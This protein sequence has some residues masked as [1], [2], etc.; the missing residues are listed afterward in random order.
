MVNK[1]D[2][3]EEKEDIIETINEEFTA[4]DISPE[5][6]EVRLEDKLKQLRQKL[7]KSEEEAKALR[8][9]LA[10]DKADYLN[11]RKRLEDEREQEKE[12]TIVRHAEKLLPLYDSFYLAML[13]KIAWEKADEMWRKGVEGIFN[14]LVGI[15]SGYNITAFD[16]N[17]ETFDPAKHEALTNISVDDNKKHN[18]IL[19]TIQVG[20]LRKDGDTERV[21]RPARV[22]VG[23][24]AGK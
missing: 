19:T 22:T 20:F 23:E 13:D 17:G 10:R 9:E 6:A 24:Y 7:A 21:I 4:E 3:H 5:D 12:R 15:L 14:Q 16:P 8:E 1:N 2:K 18:Q 11:A